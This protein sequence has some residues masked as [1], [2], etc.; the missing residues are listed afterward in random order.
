MARELLRMLGHQVDVVG[1]GA[2]A[3]EAARNNSYDVIFMDLHMPEV[4]GFAGTA[5][6]RA[7]ERNTGRPD[8][9]YHRRHRDGDGRGP[10]GLSRAGMDG[11]LSKPLHI[12]QLRALLDGLCSEGGEAVR[13][14][15]PEA[16][17][18]ARMLKQLGGDVGLVRQT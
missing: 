9:G 2:A 3:R 5:L 14:A 4:D 15:G 16:V 8:A 11:H 17:N 12:S 6:I 1:S 18:L 10:R 7:D 13:N